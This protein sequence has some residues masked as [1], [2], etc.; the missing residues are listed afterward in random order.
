MFVAD[1]SPYVPYM[2]ISEH[3]GFGFYKIEAV[4]EMGLKQKKPKI[5]EI[6]QC[7]SL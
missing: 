7:L 6:I 4:S 2:G 3:E 1:V 5:I